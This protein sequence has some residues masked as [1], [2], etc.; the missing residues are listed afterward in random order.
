MEKP[1][2]DYAFGFSEADLKEN[3]RGRLSDAQAAR[4]RRSVLQISAIIGGAVLIV[5]ILGTLSANAG[6]GELSAIVLIVFVPVAVFLAWNFLRME[7]AIRPG[8][9]SQLTGEIKLNESPYTYGNYR[10]KVGD[11]LFVL[12]RTNYQALRSGAYTFYYLPS[13]RRIV[14]VEALDRLPTDKPE[15]LAPAIE[16]FDDDSHDTL[17][18]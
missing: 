10:I 8:T 18:A 16:R 1:S 7:A 17:R 14:S 11:Q 3:R 12:A 15:P 9:V 4:L 13:I 5:T 2:L 6:A